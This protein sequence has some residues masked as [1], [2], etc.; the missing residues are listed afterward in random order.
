MTAE[1]PSVQVARDLLP[2]FHREE[3]RELVEY[4]LSIHPGDRLPARRAFDAGA[5]PRLLR[6]IVLTDVERDPYR[7]KVRVLGTAVADAFGRDFTG[8]YMDEVFAGHDS[9]LS[10]TLRVRVAE[11]G[12]PCLRPAGPGTFPG[13]EITPLEGVHLPFAGDGAVVDCVMSMFLY[14]RGT[15]SEPTGVWHIANR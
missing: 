2:Q 10:H 13:L 14:V 6:H 12:L 9:S 4:W 11:T 8:K 1:H 15:T 5:V 7:F 3:L